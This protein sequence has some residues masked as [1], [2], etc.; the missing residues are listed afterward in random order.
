M[1]D[2]VVEKLK[3]LDSASV[4]DALDKLGFRGGCLGL[5]PMV[6]GVKAVGRAFTVRYVPCG[7]VKGTVGDYLDDVQKG[8]VVVLDNAGRADCT[9]WG[10]ILTHLAI[11]KGLAGT[12]IDG[13]CRD[14]PKILQMRY[15]VYSRGRF[16]NTGKDRVEVAEVNVPVAIG[17]VQVRAGDIVFA[18]DSGVVVV[19][20]ELEEQAAEIAEGIEA[21]ERDILRKLDT[22]LSLREARVQ[23][24]YHSMQTPEQSRG[25]RG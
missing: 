15:P 16:M 10:D 4:S 24:G 20:A 12:V 14:L 22:G 19:P 6:D 1:S 21:A 17:A 8:Q 9:V 13:V 7:V 18:D 2:P 23:T 3:A 5:R 25:P 11:Q